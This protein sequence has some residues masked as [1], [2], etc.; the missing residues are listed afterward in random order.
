[1]GKTGEWSI[2]VLEYWGEESHYRITP[3]LHRS[4]APLLHHS[5]APAPAPAPFSSSRTQVS[6]LPPPCEELTTSEPARRATRVK[7]PGM[8]VTFSPDKMNGRKSR[9]RPCMVSPQKAG[10]RERG[11]TGWAT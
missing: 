6:L 7:P 8:I 11:T 9:W 3:S 1:M 2:G 5:I 4:I 10:A